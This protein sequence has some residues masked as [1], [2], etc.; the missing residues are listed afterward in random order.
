MGWAM[1]TK[2]VDSVADRSLSR[3]PLFLTRFSLSHEMPHAAEIR[4]EGASTIKSHT[5][6][7]TIQN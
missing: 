3:H 1:S 5:H 2:A 7:T 4:S 6:T